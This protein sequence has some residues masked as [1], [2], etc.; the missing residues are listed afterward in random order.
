MSSESQP[1]RSRRRAAARVTTALALLS[2]SLP[3]SAATAEKFEWNHWWLPSNHAEH[4]HAIDSLFVV[5]FWIT[6]IALVLVQAILVF[7]LI[8]YRH[9]KETKRAHFIHGNTRLEMLWTVLPALILAVLALGSKKVWDTYRWS[10]APESQRTRILVVGEQFKW[11]VVYA[12]PDNQLGKYLQYP[13]VTDPRFRVYPKKEAIRRINDDLGDAN[14]LGQIATRG[15]EREPTGLDPAGEDDDW[16]K[17]PARPLIVPVDRTIEVYV[18]SKDVL[19]S[20]ALPNFRVK[21]DAVPGMIGHVFFKAERGSES[22]KLADA[23]GL[24]R[25]S[26]LWVDRDTPGAVSDP[27]KGY[28]IVD[29]KNPAV[30]IGHLDLIGNVARG[31]LAARSVESPTDAQVDEEVK[32]LAADLKAAGRDRLPIV[33]PYEIVCMEL[34]GGEHATMR[35]EMIVV[36]Q[37]QFLNHIHKNNPPTSAA[38]PTTQPK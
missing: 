1:H 33:V 19:H 26:R 24:T 23:G 28:V 9:R 21:L 30:K 37:Q 32:A 31:R 10:D 3:A 38:T 16:D 29:P 2:T 27:D 34:C 36:T 15:E 8:K 14:P 12:G 13:K 5:I 22:T 4:G 18:G 11:N 7:F 17:I 35:G 25:N 6:V 20:F